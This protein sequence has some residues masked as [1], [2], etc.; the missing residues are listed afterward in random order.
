MKWL[1]SL[2]FAILEI[3]QVAWAAPFLSDD[4]NITPYRHYELYL[5]SSL[6][7]NNQASEEPQLQAPAIEWDLGLSQ[8]AQLQ[9]IAPYAW[10][11]PLSAQVSAANGIGDFQAGLKYRF[12][13]SRAH[14]FEMAIFPLLL[15]PSGNAGQNLG[16][17]VQELSLPI[18]MQKT[19]GAWTLNGG[20]G[21][22][23][24]AAANTRNFP[25]AGCEL[26]RVL[27]SRFTLGLE[28]YTQGAVNAQTQA[29]TIFN[30]GGFYSFTKHVS[31]LFSLGNSVLGE[32]HRVAYLGFEWT[33]GG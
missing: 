21:Y 16:N 2:F 27:N 15:L 18:W 30:A 9:I 31:L 10:A 20:G 7:K 3:I 25:Y 19:W 13:Q 22:T 23:L 24:N 28:I 29:Y 12:I 6:N 14:N 33:G 17:R 5:F 11:L 26:Q 32:Q 8:N 1:F 4:P